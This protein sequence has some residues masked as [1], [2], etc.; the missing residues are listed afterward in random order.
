[1]TRGDQL[2][3][4]SPLAAAANI[5]AAPP[6]PARFLLTNN[7]PAF[8]H[9]SV[10]ATTNTASCPLTPHMGGRNLDRRHTA[11]LHYRAAAAAGPGDES[12]PSLL[13]GGTPQLSNRN[14]LLPGENSAGARLLARQQ[15]G[16]AYTRPARR[17]EGRRLCICR[18]TQGPD[19]PPLGM[20]S[21]II[22]VYLIL[23]EVY[24]FS[25]PCFLISTLFSQYFILKYCK[26]HR[27]STINIPVT[28]K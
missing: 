23:N 6:S 27:V 5:M 18:G 20:P 8:M 7:K 3:L 25:P 17:G 13:T 10:A 12:S 19:R 21:L 4:V 26:I 1:M 22:S 16:F 14:L 2:T 24:I 9:V 15:A 28:R 11:A